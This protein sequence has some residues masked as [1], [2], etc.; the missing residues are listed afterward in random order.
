M[1]DQ[2]ATA[3]S[4]LGP[5]EVV[6]DG[7]RVRLGSAQQRRL[8]AALL[9]HANEVVSSDRLVDVLWGDEPP[10]SATHTLQTLVSRLRGTLGEGR[11]ETHPPGYRLT[12]A[13]VEVDALRFEEL[14]R[15]GLGMSEQPDVALR[16]FDDALGLWRGSPYAEFASDE[17]AAPEAAR[18]VELR[19][20]AIEE[21]AAALLELGRPDEVI[22]QLETEIAIQPFRERLRA[23]L[24]LALARAGRPVESLRAYDEFRRFLADEVGVVPS[25]GLQ[26]LNDDIVRQHP[27]ASWT[28]SPTKDAGTAGLPSG[29][30]TFLFTEVQDAP[31]LWDEYPDV[32]HNAMARHDELFRDAVTSHDGF[33]L[34]TTGDGFHAVFATAH[35]AVTGAVAAQTELLADDW[36]ITGTV[37]VRMGIHT[38]EAEYRDGDY[39]G[40]AVN[41]AKRLMSVAH[42]GQI[43]VSSVT[44]ELL[45]DVAPEKYGFVDL[46]EHRLRDLGSPERLFQVAHPDLEREFAP[47]R[48]AD[49]LPGNLPLPAS[50][51]VGRE[52]ELVRVADALAASR[53]VTLTGVGGV[54]K[55]RLALQVAGELLPSFP[56][57]VWLC[58]LAPVRDPDG[59]LD[60]IAGMFRVSQRVRVGT[61]KRPSSRICASGKRS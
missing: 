29:T 53:V 39:S 44:E 11:L 54:G 22:G 10:P 2:V 55:T 17:F 12:V 61:W 5:L 57:G 15:V 7:E 30:L 33:V 24:M 19:A 60:A 25:P 59:V 34:R 48:T 37:R 20:R 50:S 45:H 27:D 6:R 46:G 58:E 28:G 32:M 16:A 23:L 35:D 49:S 21:R 41:R 56:H 18:L 14:V 31:R 26:E 47:L 42:G 52:V 38:G 3:L 43:V 13:H 4:V 9:I 1:D 36:N 40:S 51:F 8:L